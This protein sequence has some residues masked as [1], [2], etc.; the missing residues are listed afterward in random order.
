MG[1]G[2]GGEWVRGAVWER[3]SVRCDGRGGRGV[4]KGGGGG[5]RGVGRGRE[6]RNS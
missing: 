5:G 4:V 2:E 1:G 6:K 3:K